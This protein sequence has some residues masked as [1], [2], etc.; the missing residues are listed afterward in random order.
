MTHLCYMLPEA[1]L[2]TRSLWIH[3][4]SDRQT[5]HATHYQTSHIAVGDARLGRKHTLTPSHSLET[6]SDTGSPYTWEGVHIKCTQTLSIHTSI[7]R[8]PETCQGTQTPFTPVPSA[9]LSSESKQPLHMCLGFN[10]CHM[11]THKE[12]HRRDGPNLHTQ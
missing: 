6:L 1:S 2:Q 3:M 7:C 8:I 10:R 11:N 4:E 12:V 5:L 9:T